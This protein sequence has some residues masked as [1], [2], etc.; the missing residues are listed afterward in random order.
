M[1]IF[2][3]GPKPKASITISLMDDGKVSIQT[4]STNKI[5][6]LGLLETAKQS[7]CMQETMGLIKA[8]SAETNG[9]AAILT[10]KDA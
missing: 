9:Q 6:I 7:M 3:Q 4:S 5:T 2:N 10:G 8:L 1:K